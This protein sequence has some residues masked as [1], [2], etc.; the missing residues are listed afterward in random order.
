[1]TRE[2][3]QGFLWSI[4]ENVWENV[5]AYFWFSVLGLLFVVWPIAAWIGRRRRRKTVRELLGDGFREYKSYIRSGLAIS[6][7]EDSQRFAF[8][9]SKVKVI[10]KSEEII[11]VGLATHTFIIET[12]NQNLPRIETQTF[13]RSRRLGEIYG[14]LKAMQ[15]EASSTAT[16]IEPNASTT[17][18]SVK[19][20]DAIRQLTNAVS[21]LTEMVKQL[22][23]KDGSPPHS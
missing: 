22:A 7:D 23:L 15:I 21:S 6:V 19:I 4:Q 16:A 12:K 9:D 10:C 11:G 18:E 5:W 20:E 17:T 1:M 14:R 3:I 8:A 13:F 2:T